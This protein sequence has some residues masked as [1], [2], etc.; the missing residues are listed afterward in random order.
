MF[1]KIA[2]LEARTPSR[3][4]YVDGTVIHIALGVF[5]KPGPL[6]VC[7]MG[8]ARIGPRHEGIAMHAPFRTPEAILDMPWDNKV[9]IW[10]VGVLICR[11][12]AHSSSRP[13]TLRFLTYNDRELGRE[14]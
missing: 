13:W 4:K 12:F 5:H 1:N 8:Q 10:S 11:L 14:I 3:T 6:M 2:S 9:D 7:D